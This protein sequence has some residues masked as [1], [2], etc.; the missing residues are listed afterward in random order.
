[1]IR[2]LEDLIAELQYIVSLAEDG[3]MEQAMEELEGQS[4]TIKTIIEESE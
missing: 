3:D 2:P 1:M 4:G